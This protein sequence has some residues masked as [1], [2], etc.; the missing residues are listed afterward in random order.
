MEMRQHDRRQPRLVAVGH[1]VEEQRNVVPALDPVVDRIGF[2]VRRVRPVVA[3]NPVFVHQ[4]GEKVGEIVVEGG[5]DVGAG[6]EREVVDPSERLPEAEY[7]FRQPFGGRVEAEGAAVPLQPAL[8]HDAF[9]EHSPGSVQERI[10]VVLIADMHEGMAAIRQPEPARRGLGKVD[11]EPVPVGEPE[12]RPHHQR[13]VRARF[14]PHVL[15]QAFAQEGLERVGVDV[16]NGSPGWSCSA[17]IPPKWKSSTAPG[18]R[19]SSRT[20][21]VIY[22]SSPAATRSAC[23]AGI[24]AGTRPS[25]TD[26]TISSSIPR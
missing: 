1:A 5:A 10:D 25:T 7:R 9:E 3:F 18:F 4:T 6:E 15:A 12:A 17:T 2:G 23:N 24:S 26:H 11:R 20:S 22:T 21:D 13:A 14:D 8:A 16:H 19:P